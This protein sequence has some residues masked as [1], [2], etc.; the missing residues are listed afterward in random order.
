MAHTG[1]AASPLGGDRV[2]GD[3]VGGDRA[4]QLRREVLYPQRQNTGI[5][6]MLVASAAMFFAVASSAFI[7]RSQMPLPEE[8][9]GNTR[10]LEV[11]SYHPPRIEAVEIELVH[12]ESLEE[13]ETYVVPCGEPL[14]QDNS[15]G[16]SSIVFRLCD[17]SF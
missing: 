15:D 3:R 17:E 6:V 7:L 5:G 16:P 14:F 10:V 4:Q 11:Q 2:G 13:G 9:P 12:F 8:C 1:E